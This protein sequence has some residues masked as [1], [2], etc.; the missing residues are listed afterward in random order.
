MTLEVLAE[1]HDQV[2]L[3]RMLRLQRGVVQGSQY[4]LDALHEN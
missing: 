3:H 2:Q 1:Q 4:R